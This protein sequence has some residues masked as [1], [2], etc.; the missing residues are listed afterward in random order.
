MANKNLLLANQAY[1]QQANYDPAQDVVKQLGSVLGAQNQF[2]QKLNEDA[3]EAAENLSQDAVGVDL[4]SEDGAQFMYN[5]FDR[6][7]MEIARAKAD[8]NKQL[9]RKL[10]MEGADLI[11]E[12]AAL[13]NLLKDHAQNKLEDNYSSSASTDMLDMLLTKK[14]YNVEKGSDGKL[15]IKFKATK[16]NELYLTGLFQD[17]PAAR[18]AEIA[19]L[20]S[21]METADPTEKK[22]LE[23]RIKQIKGKGLAVD[24]QEEG[25]LISDLDKHIRL[26]NEG[27]TE[28]F[29]D[30]LEEIA[31]SSQK[32]QDF[33]A[34]KDKTTKIIKQ[35]TKGTDNLQT[36]IFDDGFMQNG[37]TLAEI[38]AKDPKH[39]GMDPNKYLRSNGSEYNNYEP[40]L[41]KWVENKMLLAAENH[42]NVNSESYNQMTEA[43]RKTANANKNI[44]NFLAIENP[45]KN[46]LLMLGNAT[47]KIEIEKVD[48]G[49]GAMVD[50]YVIKKWSNGDWV[51]WRSI[52]KNTDPIVAKRVFQDALGANAQVQ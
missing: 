9:V 39:K 42:H 35:T 41:R 21:Q 3:T 20:E 10:E 38:W 28:L 1:L 46:D 18:D 36:A 16:E 33:A 31:K 23:L 19:S 2:K 37:E 27:Q 12:Q 4:M 51:E 48:D 29:S 32:G 13:G 30:Q 22:A 26:K 5:E 49:E 25:V 24:W 34:T 11:N 7:G 43:E 52:R 47:T 17:D 40:E 8:G 15:R 50:A 6:I 14:D 45:T 44:D